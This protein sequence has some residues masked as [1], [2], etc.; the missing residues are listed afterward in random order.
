MRN[1]F[2]VVTAAMVALAGAA[3]L[4]PSMA[5]PIQTALLDPS[6][7]GGVDVSITVGD[8]T[9]SVAHCELTLAGVASACGSSADLLLTG[10]SSIVKGAPVTTATITN[11][12]GPIFSAQPGD[13]KTYDLSVIL[14]VKTVGGSKE[15]NSAALGLVGSANS[16]NLSLIGTSEGVTGT[17]GGSLGSLNGTLASAAA[18]LSFVPQ[19][20]LITNKD[21]FDHTSSATSGSSP[22][23]LTFVSQ[24]FSE[25]PEPAS[26]ALLL[27]GV[28]SLGAFRRR[29]AA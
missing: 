12:T 15:I 28:A 21:I 23:I 22:M 2:K 8:L 13:T 11:S 1:A 19:S 10:T 26:I 17:P 18:P 14:T 27:T 29:R 9:V 6:Q 25:V 20:Q 3:S 4:T 16:Q 7:N 24:T 5:G